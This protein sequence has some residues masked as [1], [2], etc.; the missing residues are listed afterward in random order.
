MRWTTESRQAGFKALSTGFLLPVMVPEIDGF[1]TPF[2]AGSA[3]SQ[4]YQLAV[5]RRE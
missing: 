3:L 4:M 5:E 1:E 2:C